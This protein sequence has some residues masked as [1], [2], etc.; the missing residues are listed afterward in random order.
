MVYLHLGNLKIPKRWTCHFTRGMDYVKIRRHH[1][2]TTLRMIKMREIG[3]NIASQSFLN[4]KYYRHFQFYK[5]INQTQHF[6]DE[7]GAI[8][9]LEFSPSGNVLLAAGE[10]ASIV[11]VDPKT[12]K[13][14]NII[15]FA[16]NDSVKCICFCDERIF[17]SGSDDCNLALWDMRML[18]NCITTFS[19][20]TDSVRSLV[21]D[22]NS[23][24]LVSAAFDGT[25][26]TW[27]TNSLNEDSKIVYEGDL[28]SLYCAGVSPDG[29]TM[30]IT[31][32]FIGVIRNLDL[33]AI[34]NIQ[35][36]DKPMT[37]CIEGVVDDRLNFFEVFYPDYDYPMN[38]MHVVSMQ[39]HP[40]GK[41]FACQF[42]AKNSLDYTAI[43]D[44]QSCQ[45]RG[46]RFS[47]YIQE[48]DSAEGYMVQQSFSADGRILASPYAQCVRLLA[49]NS[50]CS[51]W[52]KES[53]P[54]T[55]QEVK[56]V[57]GHSH[58]VVCCKFSPSELLLASG[59]LG[60]DILFHEPKL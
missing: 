46:K 16:H 35:L 31:C 41:C 9:N 55:L 20:H 6:L 56:I 17:A 3:I 18:D 33:R 2:Y 38:P 1:F 34:E 26:R 50:T 29:N 32:G 4:S 8:F 52:M 30:V 43:Y 37:E 60:G 40:H 58:H 5:K 25:V 44:V 54:K 27:D 28:S 39:F 21:Y 59:C 47:H 53:H 13:H 7:H 49:F 42:I 45:G 22:E 12:K 23:G 11:F 10:E 51:M 36:Y 19:G 15:S 57:F 48:F 24:Y 14:I